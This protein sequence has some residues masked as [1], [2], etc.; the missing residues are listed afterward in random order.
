MV[1][2]L[3]AW[4]S[5][6]L[7][8]AA[9][10]CGGPADDRRRWRGV[11]VGRGSGADITVK[12]SKAPVPKIRPWAREDMRSF[13]HQAAADRRSAAVARPL[14]PAGWPCGA[15]LGRAGSPFTGPWRHLAAWL[16]L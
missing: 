13:G 1:R 5:W 8:L 12:I 15:W 11:Y 7:G 3:A 14:W 16:G 10:G 6:P 9:A 4:P 2:P